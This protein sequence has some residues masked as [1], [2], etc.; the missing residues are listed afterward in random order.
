MYAPG[1]AAVDLNR[2]CTAFDAM[3][4]VDDVTNGWGTVLFR[5]VDDE[6]GQV[7]WSSGPVHG[8]D[9]A[10]PAHVPL[11]GVKAIRLVVR[12]VHGHG[13]L[14]DGAAGVA[15]WANAVFHCG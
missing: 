4:G 7:L 13:L 10:V 11:D 3:V 9:A 14:G 2:S 1:S 15:D 12:G 5:V 6:T 8:D